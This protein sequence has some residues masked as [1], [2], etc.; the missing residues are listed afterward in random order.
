M[1]DTDALAGLTATS[2]HRGNVAEDASADTAGQVFVLDM[3]ESLP[4]VLRLR[5]WAMAALDPQPGETAV[6]VGSGTGAEVR[7]LAAAVGE[8]GRA[9]GIEPHAGLRAVATERSS[10]TGATY[11]DAE[12]TDLPFE[13][14][15]VDVVRCERVF[16]HLTDPAGAVGEFARVL[17]PGGRLVV[18]DSDWGTAVQTPGDPELLR[19]LW[20][21]RDSQSPNPHAGRHLPGQLVRTGLTVDPD[22]AATAVVPPPGAL[23][24]LVQKSLEDARAA[25]VVT[26]AECDQLVDEI[27][28]A[29]DAGQAFMAVT[30][31][32][33]LGRV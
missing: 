12:A 13:D 27:R 10:G 19:R 8:S 16:Q 21:F 20:D 29:Q 3:Q 24:V 6:D 4:G 22:V 14:A 1:A 28:A 15:S 23:L 7:R 11:L 32:A 30:M 26:Q 31:F 18:I 2:F 17:R 5:D 33:V 9:I 25:G